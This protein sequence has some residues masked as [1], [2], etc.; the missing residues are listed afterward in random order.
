MRII[1]TG[2][3]SGIG[4]AAAVELARRGHELT[5]VGRDRQRVQDV[6]REVR[7]DPYVADF[8]DLAQVRRLARDLSDKYPR[9]DGLANNAGGIIRERALTPDGH[10]RTWQSN[11]LAPFVLTQGLLPRLLESDARVVFTSSDANRWTKVDVAN[12]N[13]DGVRL[14]RG[15]RAYGQAKRADLMLAKEYA[16]RTPLH[17]YSF[18][19][20]PVATRF[21]GIDSGPLAPLIRRAIRTPEQG[22]ALLVR[23][24]TE[25][26]DAASGSYFTAW[27]KP[28]HGAA[29]QALNPAE[30]SK[31]WQLLERQAL[32]TTDEWYSREDRFALGFDEGSRRHYVSIPVTSGAVDYE[33]FYAVDDDRYQQYLADPVSALPFVVECRNREHDDLLLQKPGWNRGVAST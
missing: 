29:R 4:R 24:L 21:G 13:F 10:E 30:G 28:D 1:I 25:T 6:A 8:D 19:P 27:N 3:S 12:P 22:A 2:A 33:E 5:I 9:I 20:G 17:V 15:F 31:L 18:H 32:H 16:R 11:V 14:L 26:P 23:L 7:G